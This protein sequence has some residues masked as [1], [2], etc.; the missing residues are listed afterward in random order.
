MTPKTSPAKLRS[1]EKYEAKNTRKNVIFK[2]VG[3]K[4]LI[5]AI[6]ADKEFSFS[7]LVKSLLRSHYNLDQK[8]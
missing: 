5:D 7:P 2:T 3:D 4:D 6:D 1:N 8:D